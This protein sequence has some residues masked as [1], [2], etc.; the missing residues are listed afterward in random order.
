MKTVLITG[1]AGFTAAYLAD[2]ILAAYG[3][4]CSVYG[5]DLIQPTDARRIAFRP[6]DLLAA[7][8]VA[9]LLNELKPSRIYH[10]AGCFT[11][12]FET[13]YQSNVTTTRI[14][15]DGL[16][17]QGQN[18]CRMLVIGSAAEYGRPTARHLPLD[19][20]TPLRPTTVYGL[21][22]V[23]QTH[24]AQCYAATRGLPVVIVRPFNL[25]GKGISNRLFIGRLYE[26]IRG[27]KAGTL[28]KIV[29]GDLTD[30]RDYIDVRDA[31]GAYLTALENGKTG[32]VYNVG[33]GHL[34]SIERLLQLFLAQ[35]N[36]GRERVQSTA[37]VSASSGAFGFR[38]DIA[39][40]SALGW[41]PRIPIEET[42]GSFG[43]AGQE[44]D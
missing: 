7:S 43:P 2:A 15:L 36:I 16:V 17:A 33:S 23:F 24:L 13:D 37:S 30:T 44:A 8:Q 27:V 42:V 5:T 35:W 10:L 22:K 34:V 28:E 38:A 26:Q 41:T 32:E 12:D 29:L 14:L 19:E 18:D 4:D 39:K 25:I 1:C 6:C 3:S 31:V 9:T 21:T 11:N 20:T 40:I